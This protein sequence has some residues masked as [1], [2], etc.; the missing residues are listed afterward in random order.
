M[1]QIS[2][3]RNLGQEEYF[4]V[5]SST[6]EITINP[7]DRDALATEVFR[8]TIVAY[9]TEDVDSSINSTIIIIVEDINDH[10]PEIS[11]DELTIS[12]L[13]ET[14]MTLAFDESIVITDPDLVS[15]ATN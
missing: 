5:D 2:S 1:P 10:T 3:S 11:P 12:I 9:E 15:I 6:G 8:F 13:E 14:Y 7:I 4:L